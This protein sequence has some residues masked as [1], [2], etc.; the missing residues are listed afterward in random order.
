MVKKL[1]K[2]YTVYVLGSCFILVSSQNSLAIARK[3]YAKA[4]GLHD[5]AAR[6]EFKPMLFDAIDNYKEM[7]RLIHAKYN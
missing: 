4:K 1:L 7:A 3:N 5:D 6:I 2:A